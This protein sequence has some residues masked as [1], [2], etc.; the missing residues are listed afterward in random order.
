MG[1]TLRFFSNYILQLRVISGRLRSLC[2]A[3]THLPGQEI[4]SFWNLP[5]ILSAQLR[6]TRTSVYLGLKLHLQ[7]PMVSTGC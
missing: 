6:G 1:H 7:V 4:R 5:I 2:T 3:L